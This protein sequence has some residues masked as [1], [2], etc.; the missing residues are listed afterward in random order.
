MKVRLECHVPYTDETYTGTIGSAYTLD[1]GTPFPGSI[2]SN[3]A[4]FLAALLE[5]GFDPMEPKSLFRSFNPERLFFSVSYD[6]LARR[7]FPSCR[8]YDVFFLIQSQTDGIRWVRTYHNKT[9]VHCHKVLEEGWKGVFRGT[10]GTFFNQSL[11]KDD[12]RI[13]FD[14]ESAT[15]AIR[16][17]QNLVKVLKE[18]PAFV[19]YEEVERQIRSGSLPELSEAVREGEPWSAELRERLKNG[20]ETALQL[21]KDRVAKIDRTYV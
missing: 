17:K 10:L 13:P 12:P 7:G 16:R 19:A 4:A 6:G 15:D 3:L 21:D 9:E 20:L 14:R 11:P 2:Q 1:R 18:E 5:G 8:R